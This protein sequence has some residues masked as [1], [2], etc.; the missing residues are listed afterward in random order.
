MFSKSSQNP[1]I[2]RMEPTMRKK[3]K[4]VII[5][6]MIFIGNTYASP[7]G[8]ATIYFVPSGIGSDLF[9]FLGSNDLNIPITIRNVNT[10]K[11]SLKMSGDAG[12]KCGLKGIMLN[13]YPLLVYG[14]DC[15]VNDKNIMDY[16]QKNDLLSIRK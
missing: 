15:I 12:K 3:L 9:S 2:I 16:M 1:Y 11:K 7:K 8:S 5:F 10:D 6:A 4:L 14:K 13:A